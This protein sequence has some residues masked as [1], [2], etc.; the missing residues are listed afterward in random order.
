MVKRVVCAVF[1]S[2][3]QA[4]GSPVFS[5]AVGSAL[6]AFTDEANRAADGN[7]LYAH[8]DD[9]VL[10]HIADFNDETGVFTLPEGGVRVLARGKDVKQS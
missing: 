6:R 8:P 3:V 7:Q 2:A 4:F 10:H 1:D 9:F 5:P